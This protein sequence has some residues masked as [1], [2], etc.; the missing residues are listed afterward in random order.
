M[1]GLYADIDELQIVENSKIN[2]AFRIKNSIIMLMSNDIK[3]VFDKINRSTSV[4]TTLFTDG[5]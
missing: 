5:S 3:S 1:L 4:Y 2:F